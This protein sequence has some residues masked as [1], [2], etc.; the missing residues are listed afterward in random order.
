MYK[1]E[2]QIRQQ[3]EKEKQKLEDAATAQV[4]ESYIATFKGSDTGSSDKSKTFVR[5]GIFNPG[6]VA[7]PTETSSSSSSSSSNIPSNNKETYTLGKA[8][9]CPTTTE[10]ETKPSFGAIPRKLLATSSTSSSSSS[11]SSTSNAT[12]KKS[13]ELTNAELVKTTTNLFVKGIPQTI[14]EEGLFRVF[15]TCGPVASIRIMW[16]RQQDDKTWPTN[17]GFVAYMRRESAEKAFAELNGFVLADSELHV[18]WY[19]PIPVPAHPLAIVPAADALGVPRLRTLGVWPVTPEQL[20]STQAVVMVPAPSKPSVVVTPPEDRKQRYI[21][22]YT[23]K[24][25]AAKGG[26]KF[27]RAVEEAER[28]NP[29][30]AFLTDKKSPEHTYYKWRVYSYTQGDTEHK[31]FTGPFQMYAGGPWWLPPPMPAAAAAADGAEGGDCGNPDGSGSGS[32]VPLSPINVRKL[33]KFLDNLT[34][35]NSRICQVMGFALDHACSAEQVV[36][37]VA[38]SFA[39]PNAPPPLMI[40]R[41]FLV[42]DILY[43]SS[44]PAKNAYAYKPLFQDALPGIFRCLAVFYYSLQGR[45]TAM[46]FKDQVDRVVGVWEQWSLFPAG[47]VASLRSAFDSKPSAESTALKRPADLGADAGAPSN[48]KQNV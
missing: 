36:R 44:S 3:R 41:L 47:F 12:H 10:P 19:K 31:W 29:L 1:N 7:P 9:S 8:E 48:K 5:G 46:H 40:A 28:G 23:A 39:A 37:V 27:E 25:V 16:P 20:R 43:N 21:I 15:S 33:G 4:Y 45:L 26:R 38:E 42:S 35:S 22:D 6:E 32:K 24:V 34:I 11:S 14:D 13:E 30:Y 17:K 18:E 2:F